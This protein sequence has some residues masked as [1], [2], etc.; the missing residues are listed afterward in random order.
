M[1]NN[2][3]D[4]YFSEMD[5]REIPEEGKIQYQFTSGTMVVVDKV[6]KEKYRKLWTSFGA[7][8]ILLSYLQH[9]E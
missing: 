7:G 6:L 8:R 5:E 9:L 2:L 4:N 1:V 3:D